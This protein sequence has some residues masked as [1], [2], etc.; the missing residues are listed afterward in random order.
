[1]RRLPPSGRLEPLSDIPVFVCSTDE[2]ASTV[3]FNLHR[4]CLA[5]AERRAKKL[6][7]TRPELAIL[8]AYFGGCTFRQVAEQLG[9][10]E[11][12]AKSRLRLGLARLAALLEGLT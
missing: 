7:M 4:G 9:I 11:G 5:L 8:L 10:P 1:M 6:G 2:L 3:G 12:T